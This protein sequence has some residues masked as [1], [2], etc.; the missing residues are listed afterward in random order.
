MK[1]FTKIITILSGISM[2]M[3]IFFGVNLATGV[4]NFK[5]VFKVPQK[6]EAMSQVDSQLLHEVHELQH[7]S[8]LSWELMRLMTDDI[9]T[10]M[11]AITYEDGIPY[12]IDIRQTAEG[13]ELAFVFKQYIVYPLRHSPADKRKYIVIHDYYTGNSQNYYLYE[14]N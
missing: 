9:D 3:L 12:N 4:N 8:E 11:Y 5:S 1:T 13:V 7:A 2:V 14:L 10:L 6:I